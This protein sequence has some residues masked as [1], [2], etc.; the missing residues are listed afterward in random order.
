MNINKEFLS[1]LDGAFKAKK[2]K[3]SKKFKSFLVD[4]KVKFGLNLQKSFDEVEMSVYKKTVLKEK[5]F[6]AMGI[7]EKKFEWRNY[8]QTFAAG[9][10]ALTLVFTS[11]FDYSGGIET[12]SASSPI[13]V[14]AVSGS[15][16]VVRLGNELEVYPGFNLSPSDRVKTESGFVEM[17]FA[18]TSV[19]RVD[20][21]SELVVDDLNN[22]SGKTDSSMTIRKG[23][24]WF[25]A[26]GGGDRL[27]EYNF[28]TSEMLVE[29]DDDSI[30]HLEVND[31][32][33]QVAVF[34]ESAEVNYKTQGAFQTSVL[35]KGDLIKVKQEQDAISVV[36]TVLLADDIQVGKRNWY[37]DN[38]KKDRLYEQ[39]L[40]E[41]SL[42]ASRK[43]VKITSDSLWYPLK[44]A[45]RATKLALTINPVKKAAVELEIADEK[46]HEAKILSDEGKKDLA[47]E[48][49]DSYKKNVGNVLDIASKVEVETKDVESS[50]KLKNEAKT[51]VETHKKDLRANI[52]SEEDLKEVLLDT[53]LQVAEASGEKVKVKLKQLDEE[54][55]SINKIES[56]LSVDGSVGVEKDAKV[57]KVIVDFTATVKEVTE[58]EVEL[59][60]D[61]SKLIQERALDLSKIVKPEESPELE[62]TVK[63]IGIDLKA[64][65]D[66][67][68]QA[69]DIE[70][71]SF[72]QDVVKS[73]IE[74]DDLENEI[75]IESKSEVE[76]VGETF[77][78]E[79]DV[80]GEDEVEESVE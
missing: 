8:I 44:E 1:D 66:K 52:E 23:S 73:K 11:V 37:L 40:V 54:I 32:Y 69:Q 43:K 80:E 50:V 12:A 67:E 3:N 20:S 34:G 75:L 22:F 19:L 35:R 30:I 4:D 46:L 29:I 57:K 60:E 70:D 7:N 18:D 56:D 65:V 76:D 79:I 33:G 61:V 47:K 68:K 28:K 26:F 25:N 49:L 78:D 64:E 17:I 5:L 59:D 31:L 53:E 55:D 41:N 9:F 45:Q 14:S 24:I 27:S 10:M 74:L 21:N 51:L 63:G 72:D 58:S 13:S 48:T 15:V 16:K 6:V 2:F 36:D 71:A 39:S 77:E 62:N 38:M 42:L